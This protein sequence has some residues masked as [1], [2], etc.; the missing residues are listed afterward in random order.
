[1]ADER[2]MPMTPFLNGGDGANEF[3]AKR[4]MNLPRLVSVIPI[5]YLKAF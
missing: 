1:M 5:F 3:I 2:A 4:I